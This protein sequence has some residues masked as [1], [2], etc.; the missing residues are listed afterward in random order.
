MQGRPVQG[1]LTRRSRHPTNSLQS[2]SPS[3]TNPTIRATSFVI[4]VFLSGS[5]CM[6]ACVRA[7]VRAYVR[8]CVCVR[9]RLRECCV[10]QC[11]EDQYRGD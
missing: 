7:S 2:C 4:P 1:R 10:I 8:A 5:V 11:R 3:N 6:C 9:V